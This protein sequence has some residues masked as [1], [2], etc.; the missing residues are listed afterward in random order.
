MNKANKIVFILCSSF[1][2]PLGEWEK[3]PRLQAKTLVGL[4][5]GKLP[6]VKS[7]G[8]RYQVPRC[9]DHEIP[10]AYT[11]S[12]YCTKGTG[13]DPRDLQGE[14]CRDDQRLR[15]SG[16][17]AYIWV[18]SSVPCGESVGEVGQGEDIP[19]DHDGIQD[20]ESSILESSQW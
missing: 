5:Y 1:I 20:I 11:A 12:R 2:V 10:Q 13:F 16:S 8:I 4:R 6:E 18:G 19:Q 15:S 3:N 14:R 17:C 7:Y 9:V